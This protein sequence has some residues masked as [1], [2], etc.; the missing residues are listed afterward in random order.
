LASIRSLGGLDLDECQPQLGQ[1]VLQLRFVL[2][3]SPR[4]PLDQGGKGI[5][6]QPGLVELGWLE[7]QVE[8]RQLEQAEGVVRDDQVDRRASQLLLEL[9]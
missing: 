8:G 4:Q 2:P 7:T 6:G 1:P 9:L 5:D 3:E